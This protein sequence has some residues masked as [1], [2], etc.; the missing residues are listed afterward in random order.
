[1]QAKINK[2]VDR[3]EFSKLY[4]SVMANGNTAL[5]PLAPADARPHLYLVPPSPK[6]EASVPA[7]FSL[8]HLSKIILGFVFAVCLLALC[9]GNGALVGDL[10]GCGAVA[11]FA[12]LCLGE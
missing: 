11:Y 8:F 10:L 3:K 2:N 7:S 12:T 6:E 1:M 5:K 4:D 9:S